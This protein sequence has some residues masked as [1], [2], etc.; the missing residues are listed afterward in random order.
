MTYRGWTVK[1]SSSG[2]E[3]FHA[4][5]PDVMVIVLPHLCFVVLPTIVILAAMAAER[6]AFR[7][8]YLSQSGKKKDDHFQKSRRQVEH[9]SLWSGRWIRKILIV[10]CLVVLWKHWKVYL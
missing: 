6:T 1:R 4:G 9:D 2:N 5:T 3:A 8:H 10:L 7:E